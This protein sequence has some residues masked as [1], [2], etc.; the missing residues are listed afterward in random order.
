[1]SATGWDE[2]YR[3]LRTRSLS[4]R[5]LRGD[6]GVSERRPQ[7]RGTLLRSHCLTFSDAKTVGQ[8]SLPRTVRQ[9]PGLY[10]V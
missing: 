9:G 6:D 10:H 8:R 3:R 5:D 2:D 4:V 1:M 7:S